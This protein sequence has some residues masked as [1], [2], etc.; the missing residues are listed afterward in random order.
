MLGYA[1]ACVSCAKPHAPRTARG[2]RSPVER[3]AGGTSARGVTAGDV[4]CAA[5]GAGGGDAASF[6]QQ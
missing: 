3:D 1:R 5:G 4:C 6:V 2:V